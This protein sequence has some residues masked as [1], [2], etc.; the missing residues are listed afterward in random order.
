MS[1]YGIIN[2]TTSVVTDVIG[3]AIGFSTENICSEIFRA[4]VTPHIEPSTK[5][6]T[7]LQTTPHL[8][9]L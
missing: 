4:V 8:N 3:Q 2:D 5:K 6:I 7:N 1:Q 9:S